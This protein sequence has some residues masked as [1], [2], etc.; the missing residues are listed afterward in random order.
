MLKKL[1]KKWWKIMKTVY[2]N[3][4]TAFNCNTGIYYLCAMSLAMGTKTTV[5]RPAGSGIKIFTKY[6]GHAKWGLWAITF[7][8]HCSVTQSC[9][10][11][12]DPMDCS[13]SGSPVLHHHPELAQTHVHWVGD[14]IQPSYPLSSP[15][16]PAFYVSQHQDVFRWISSLH[17]V[18]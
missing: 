17:Q 8:C 3:L 15:S 4:W 18:A 6:N 12:Y 2:F 1:Y 16:P 13:T 14:P 5:S 9:L 11:F 10:T 7:I